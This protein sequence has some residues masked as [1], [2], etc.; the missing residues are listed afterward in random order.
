MAKNPQRIFFRMYIVANV[1]TVILAFVYL[2]REK[3]C[4][5]TPSDILNYWNGYWPGLAVMFVICAAPWTVHYITKSIISL[6]PGQTQIAK[7]KRF[8][9]KWFATTCFGT[10]LGIALTG[11]IDQQLSSHGFAFRVGNL[12]AHSGLTSLVCVAE[13]MCTFLFIGGCIS[14]A[15][16]F[17][18]EQRVMIGRWLAFSLLGLCL[19]GFV[20]AIG[21]LPHVHFVDTFLW[22]IADVKSFDLNS[23]LVFLEPL[24]GS[25][26]L[27]LFTGFWPAHLLHFLRG[28]EGGAICALF[29]G[30]FQYRA[31]KVGSRENN[32]NPWFLPSVL[33][34]SL[35]LGL[36][37]LSAYFYVQSPRFICA[38]FCAAILGIIAGHW[39]PY[40]KQQLQPNIRD[41]R[42]LRRIYLASFEAY[43]VFVA[44]GSVGLKLSHFYAIALGFSLATLAVTFLAVFLLQAVRLYLCYSTKALLVHAVALFVPIIG[45]FIFLENDSRLRTVLNSSTQEPP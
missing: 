36:Y 10:V 37:A 29:I 38:V 4:Y 39:H 24:L 22:E 17:A 34:W 3:D 21:M 14:L 26:V 11:I 18:L 8:S 15:Q 13:T 20:A 44:I 40:T 9:L 16:S 45:L 2:V 1:I 25:A 6:T 31:D 33:G 41:L 35:V 28:L 30:L 19:G 12:G 42:R 5:F 43:L 23:R 7:G 32:I 27:T